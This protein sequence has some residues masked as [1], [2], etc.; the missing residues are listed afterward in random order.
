MRKKLLITSVAFLTFLGGWAL[1]GGI[2]N[3]EILR[4]IKIIILFLILI[5]HIISVVV[6]SIGEKDIV[7]EP[8]ATVVG[9][10]FVTGFLVG[11]LVF[12]SA[13]LIFLVMMFF[14][15]VV[16]ILQYKYK[17]FSNKIYKNEP[18]KDDNYEELAK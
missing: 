14:V 17:T 7:N 4:D 16:A 9:I 1:L 15:F 11:F 2:G 12:K 18:L 10:S 6:I 13:I 3:G 5:A 8:F